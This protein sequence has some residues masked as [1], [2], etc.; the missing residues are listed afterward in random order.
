MVVHMCHVS[1][2]TDITGP[3]QWRAGRNQI[4]TTSFEAFEKHAREQLTQALGKAGL[5]TA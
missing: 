3:D 2:F 5:D 1:L 4:L